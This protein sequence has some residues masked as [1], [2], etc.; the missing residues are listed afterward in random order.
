MRRTAAVL[1]LAPLLA[2]AQAGED[3]KPDAKP[4]VP[5]LDL[6]ASIP[7]PGVKGRLDHMAL[8]ARRKRLYLAALGNGTVEALSIEKGACERSIGELE[9]PQG[10]AFL[11]DL[12][13][14]VVACG[15]DG[16]VRFYRGET[17]DLAAK[18]DL[19]A[20]AD[21]VRYDAATQKVYVGFG[22]GAIAAIAAK[23]PSVLAKT[24]VGAHPESF[25]LETGGRRIFVNVAGKAEV[26][27]VDRF[28]MTSRERWKTGDAS[29]NFPMAL[30][31]K[32]KRLFVGCRDPASLVVLDTESGKVV[33]KIECSGDPDD[34]FLDAGRSRVYVACGAGTIDVF[35][36]EGNDTVKLR[37]KVETRKG[38]RTCL[39][40]A[41]S[42][43]LFLAAPK[44]GELP[45][46]VRIY[47]PR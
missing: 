20:D 22:D 28:E 1:V 6:V 36:R 18:V 15:G 3:S 23:T 12:D 41:E 17:L 27:V 8:D 45:A 26:A 19:G 39:Y 47:A 31:E 29:A 21:N 43:R 4:A 42:D 11:A 32:G 33:T 24:D 14:L 7:M 38:A 34:V 10:V 2:V 9:A 13:R 40:D 35:D 30:D 5:P 25:Q 46:E 16:S 44:D 37:A